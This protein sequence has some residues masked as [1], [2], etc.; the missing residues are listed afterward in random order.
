MLLDVPLKL[1]LLQLELLKPFE[2]GFQLLAFFNQLLHE[3]LPVL[4]SELDECSLVDL[5]GRIEADL[6]NHLFPWKLS[7]DELKCYV[8]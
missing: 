8:H 7:V 2:E 1:F 4:P 6:T 3:I 5:F